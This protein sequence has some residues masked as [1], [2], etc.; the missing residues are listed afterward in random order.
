MAG[1]GKEINITLGKN[2]QLLG[3]DVLEPSEIAIVN[4]LLQNYIKKIENKTDY[5][6]FRLAL[7]MHQRSKT[8]IHELKAELFIHPGMSIGSTVSDKNLYRATAEVIKN[9][10]SELEHLKK[11]AARN[12]PIKK[13]SRK[14]I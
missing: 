13:L 11:K 8:F 9:L 14:I 10:L 12:R 4:D 7:K 2:V 6:L 3:F 5:E 1:K